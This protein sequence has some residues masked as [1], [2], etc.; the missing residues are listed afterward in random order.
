MPD[1]SN[2]D[3]HEPSS[4]DAGFKAAR[5]KILRAKRHF[6][7][8]QEVTFEYMSRSP[9][10]L[11]VGYDSE[12]EN[13]IIKMKQLSD[14]PEEIPIIVGDI[15]HNLRS[16]LDV[17]V[18][19]LVSDKAKNK[20]NIKFP[21]C[22]SVEK[23]NSCIKDC[24][25]NKCDKKIV[26][27]IKST[28]PF[29]DGNKLLYCISEI[30]NIDK[31]RI[32]LPVTTLVGISADELNRIHPSF[33]SIFGDGILVFSCPEF[34]KIPLIGMNRHQRRW[35]RKYHGEFRKDKMFSI[36]LGTKFATDSNFLDVIQSS[37]IEISNIV[38][39]LEGVLLNS[40]ESA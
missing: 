21:F 38:D 3:D 8:L 25:I 12:K 26:D 2:Q 36:S 28:Q 31:H 5:M 11:S 24:E 15:F 16:S 30:N 33:P 18:Y 9:F 37:I 6:S 4:P 32:V 34:F 40:T 7:E 1:P 23:L 14:I 17:M 20:K 22:G 13:T 29:P 19:G 10:R 35:E 27:F 39:G